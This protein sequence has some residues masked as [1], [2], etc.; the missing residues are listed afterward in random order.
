MLIYNTTYHVEDDVH[1]NF[2]IWLRESLIVEVERDG[3]LKAPRLCKLLSHQDE[4]TSYSL[5][6]SVENSGLLHA[7]FRQQGSK[8]NAELTQIFGNKVV[9]FPTLM[10]EM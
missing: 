3:R 1:D 2:L 9:G 5:Q 4:G 10:E 7:W 6:W 8:L